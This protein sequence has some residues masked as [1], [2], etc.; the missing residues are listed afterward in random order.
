MRTACLPA[1]AHKA[2]SLSLPGWKRNKQTTPHTAISPVPP[3]K[4]SVLQGR[5]KADQKTPA[6]PFVLSKHNNRTERDMAKQTVTLDFDD[7][8]VRIVQEIADRFGIGAEEY[9]RA[10]IAIHV[11]ALLE[12]GEDLG[13]VH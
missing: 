1:W 6:L 10:L 2:G 11:C 4:P 3:N 5:R 13:P 7:R 9:M 8:F 12:G